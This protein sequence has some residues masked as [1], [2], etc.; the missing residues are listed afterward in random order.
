M[1]EDWRGEHFI[2]KRAS[3]W[4]HMIAGR[5]QKTKQRIRSLLRCGYG[6]EDIAL[7]LKIAVSKVREEVST[8]RAR[9]NLRR[10]LGLGR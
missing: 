4:K 1:T 2:R 3:R 6:T 9:G 8:L 5:E 10:V 7:R